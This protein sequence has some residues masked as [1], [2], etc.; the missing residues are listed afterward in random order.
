MTPR[1][2]LWMALVG[3]VIGVLCVVPAYVIPEPAPGTP[4]GASHLAVNLIILGY[5]GGIVGLFVM[6]VGSVMAGVGTSVKGSG[7]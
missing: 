6:I 2:G 4:G 7:K 1:Q 5:V 3:L